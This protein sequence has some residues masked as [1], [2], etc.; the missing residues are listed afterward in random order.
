[1]AVDA[2]NGQ[3]VTGIITDIGNTGSNNGG[4]SKF[5]VELTMDRVEGMLSGMNATAKLLI[6][7]TEAVPVIPA[8]ALALLG[9]KTVVY[10]GYDEKNEV[11]TGPVEVTLGRSDGEQVE[12]LAGLKLGDTVKY[13]YYDTMEISYTPTFGGGSGFNFGR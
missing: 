1:M 2:L 7:K 13:A 11:L 5:T 3:I 9:N 12:I 4:S 8:A 10:T 6:H